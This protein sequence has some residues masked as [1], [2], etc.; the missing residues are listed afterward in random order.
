MAAT[1]I[2][3]DA[4]EPPRK[5]RQ[6][7]AEDA[8]LW[9][10]PRAL[11]PDDAWREEQVS[12]FAGLDPQH[13][14]FDLHILVL[15]VQANRFHQLRG[16]PNLGAR[17]IQLLQR[18]RSFW[19]LRWVHGCRRS[20]CLWWLYHEQ[21]RPKNWLAKVLLKA[22]GLQRSKRVKT[23][24]LIY[25]SALKTLSS[26][27]LSKHNKWLSRWYRKHWILPC[28][29]SFETRCGNL[30]A[31][32]ALHRRFWHLIVGELWHCSDRQSDDRLR[33]MQ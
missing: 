3:S 7:S 8:K 13:F 5:V 27:N 10:L 24:S 31:K 29:L 22:L 18:N 16:L 28:R 1:S 14:H 12:H 19:F 17:A 32:I 2:S 6:I 11:P 33:D 15:C 20:L 26:S 30:W 4:I 21:S 25:W 23:W 9:H